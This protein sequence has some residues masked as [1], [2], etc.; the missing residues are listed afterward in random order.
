MDLLGLSCSSA[1]SKDYLEA[2]WYEFFSSRERGKSLDVHFPWMHSED[3]CTTF[4]ELRESGVLCGG[5]VL[6]EMEGGIA[7]NVKIKFGAVGLV[8]VLPQYRGRGYSRRLLDAVI[9]HARDIGLKA[10]TLWTS[11]PDVYGNVGFVL[12][13]SCSFG[14][15]E[16][17][18]MVRIRRSEASTRKVPTDRPLP[19]FATG[20]TQWIHLG[21][22]V[23]VLE[24]SEGPILAEWS[25]CPERIAILLR[26][27]MPEKWRINSWEGDPL[28]DG[29]VQLG[30]RINVVP[31]QLQMWLPLEHV[32][33]PDM[34]SRAIRIS[35]LERI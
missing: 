1:G 2:V 17:D 14:W 24:D 31:T 12:K 25:G 22:T 5:L 15:V 21:D 32:L 19:P 34:L 10:L 6:R 23:T 4:V 18:N 20:M 13:D 8:C 30:F 11:K 35:V 27:E 9:C 3:G 16:R 33:T 26:D 29:L 7:Q 28:L